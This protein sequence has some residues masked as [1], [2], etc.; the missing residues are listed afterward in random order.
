MELSMSSFSIFPLD[1]PQLSFSE[2]PH[3]WLSRNSI[4][5]KLETKWGKFCILYS[6]TLLM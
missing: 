4:P 6:E 1:F 2:F 5:S 3:D